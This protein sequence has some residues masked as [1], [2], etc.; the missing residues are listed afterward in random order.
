MTLSLEN[1]Y[2]HEN[3]EIS[4][5]VDSNDSRA[6]EISGTIEKKTMTS[7]AIAAISHLDHPKSI[8]EICPDLPETVVN[9]LL[10]LVNQLLIVK[11]N[12]EK[13]I[14]IVAIT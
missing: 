11:I 9:D 12:T 14:K 10:D 7:N 3:V 2:F 6:N 1:Q 4:P 13:I 5:G 8:F